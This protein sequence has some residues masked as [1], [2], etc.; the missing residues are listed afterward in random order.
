MKNTVGELVRFF[1]QK[2][3]FS[4][5]ESYDN[6]GLLIGDKNDVVSGVLVSLDC[7]EKVVLEAIEKGCNVVLSHHPLIFKGIKRL[8]FGNEV[9]RTIRLAIKNDI[10]ILAIHTNLDNHFEGVNRRIGEKIGV[11]KSEILAQKDHQLYKLVVNV[12]VGHL[13][14]LDKAIF[15][16]GAGSIGNYAECRFSSTGEG[17]FLPL[18]NAQPFDGKLGQR[19]FVKEERVEYLLPAH[20]VSR[21]LEAMHQTHPYEEVAYDL[22]LLE[23]KHQ[24]IGAGMIGELEQSMKL[25]H[26]L[27]HIKTAFNCGVI[28]HTVSK[29]EEV[30][31]IAWCGGAGS[32]L[33]PEA[34]RQ[35]ADIFL[36]GDLKYHDFFIPEQKMVLADIGHF[37]SEQFTSDLLVEELNRNFANF[38]VRLTEQNTNPINYF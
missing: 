33:I 25:E 2:F 5:Q 38:A 19:S 18:E 13:D 36:T 6:S 30:K 7:T 29:N 32:F 11:V 23:N 3:P 20:R 16:E 35:K 14:A 17:T 27:A 34:M 9:E 24:R 31:K 26:F 10:S 28:R 22:Y 37:E 21:V 12:P 1:E 4:L 15:N 8:N